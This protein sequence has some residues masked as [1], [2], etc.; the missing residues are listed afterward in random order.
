MS[1]NQ[2]VTSLLE[3]LQEKVGVIF[4]EEN[5]DEFNEHLGKMA[6]LELNALGKRI[7]LLFAF[8]SNISHI[9]GDAV[10]TNSDG[11]SAVVM[12]KEYKFSMTNELSMLCSL[13]ISK[14]SNRDVAI[15]TQE[16]FDLFREILE[17]VDEV[18]WDKKMSDSEASILLLNMLEKHLFK[19]IN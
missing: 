6:K 15:D 5:L 18:A 17:K 12:L 3:T 10:E 11:I 14:A 16:K 2:E 8:V 13:M 1:I 7:N 19:I 9:A 4:N